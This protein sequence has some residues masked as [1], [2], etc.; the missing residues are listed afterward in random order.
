MAYVTWGSGRVTGTGLIII[1]IIIIIHARRAWRTGQTRR[2][3]VTTTTGPGRVW[4]PL[5]EYTGRAGAAEGG[6]GRWGG[7]GWG[8]VSRGVS[9]CTRRREEATVEMLRAGGQ[10]IGR[11]VVSP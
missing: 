11:P 9:R 6:G 10:H 3:L 1:I 5:E 8:G 2:Q 4:E 7:A